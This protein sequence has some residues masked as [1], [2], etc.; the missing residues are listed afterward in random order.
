MAVLPQTPVP[1]G[2]NPLPD[3]NNKPPVS[4]TGG[5]PGQSGIAKQ[6][7]QN[8]NPLLQQHVTDRLSKG[9]GELS[10][11]TR[12]ELA[13]FEERSKQVRAEEELKL[14]RLGVL[15]NAGA[16]LRA[17]PELTGQLE[18]ARLDILA[19]GEER[20]AQAFQGG[21]ALSGQAAGELFTTAGL[22]GELFGQKTLAQQQQ[23]IDNDNAALQRAISQGQTTG[24]FTDPVTGVTQDTLQARLA[25]KQ[26]A[27]DQALALG[28]IDGQKTIAQQQ[29]DIDNDNAALQ[30]AISQGNVTGIF[31]DP[32]TGVASDILQK[33]LADKQRALDEAIAL[34]EVGGE[35]TLEGQS[36]EIDQLNAALQRAISQGQSTGVFVDPETGVM[37]DTLEKQ[38]AD[39]QQALAEAALTGVFEGSDTLSG[40]KMAIDT[41]NAALQRAISQGQL[42]GTF[43]DPV[44][45]A[46]Q[47]TLEKHIAD[48]QQ[49]LDEAALTGVFD[50]E[51]TLA[52]QQQNLADLNAAMDRAI[53]QGQLTGTFIDPDTNESSVSLQSKIADAQQKHQTAQLTELNRAAVIEENLRALNAAMDRAVAQ[54]QLTGV[55][56]DPDTGKGSQTL[57]A[58][59]TRAELALDQ[60]IRNGDMVIN[61][62]DV[63]VREAQQDVNALNAAMARAIQSGEATGEFTDP[64]SGD[65]QETL[66]AELNRKSAALAQSQHNLQE[67]LAVGRFGDKPTLDKLRLDE[68]VRAAKAGEVISADQVAEITRSNLAGERLQS[69][70]LT[71]S[72]T[73][74]DPVTQAWVNTTTLESLQ[75]DFDH[76]LE[77]GNL[78]G[79]VKYE[80]ATGTTITKDTMAA[81][82]M[83]FE[84]MQAAGLIDIDP[85]T[86]QP[87]TT[88]MQTL[89]AQA[90]QLEDDIQNGKLSLQQQA[91]AFDQNVTEAEITGLYNKF[92]G[93]AGQFFAA[94]DTSLGDMNFIAEFDF[95]ADGTINNLDWNEFQEASQGG[96]V[97]TEGAKALVS[98]LA[99]QSL[100]RD[101]ETAGVTGN[102]QYKDIDGNTVTVQT[103]EELDRLFQQDIEAAQLFG[104]RPPQTFSYDLLQEKTEGAFVKGTDPEYDAAFDI[105]QDG[106]TD[107]SDRIVYQ[108]MMDAA[109]RNRVRGLLRSG[110]LF[111]DL[112]FKDQVKAGQEG[113]VDEQGDIIPDAISIDEETRIDFLGGDAE[114]GA[115]VYRPEGSLTL[116][117]RQLGVTEA[118]VGEA[119]RQFNRTFGEEVA[120][121]KSQMSG[122]MV[123]ENGYAEFINVWNPETQQYDIRQPTTPER[124]QFELQMEQIETLMLSTEAPSFYRINESKGR[125]KGFERVI[126]RQEAI[127]EGYIN[128][129]GS[130]GWRVLEKVGDL[131][132]GS[133]ITVDGTS[134]M[135]D[136]ARNMGLEF[137]PDSPLGQEQQFALIQS[138]MGLM[139]QP[140]NPTFGPRGPTGA[141]QVAGIIDAFIPD[142]IGF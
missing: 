48:N 141:Q 28:T 87:S 115:Y 85:V 22:T 75:Q 43:V 38:I 114:T 96:G 37:Q 66:Q 6:I 63:A 98:E 104:E 136:F 120:Q 111:D 134:G 70:E 11:Q 59:L 14:Q 24:V 113:M 73:H 29:Q 25:D 86:G 81:K 26:H 19:R 89:E 105:N 8:I 35:L 83:A 82:L 49:A 103:R 110:V 40:Q 13:D 88:A 80:D 139:F 69:G 64:I 132:E 121:F 94:M 97:Q 93:R 79:A 32:V 138:L 102:F 99:N 5:L 12:R 20:R 127:D 117:A 71:G 2:D 133:T 125:I 15:R 65:S 107:L 137:D 10:A 36:L 55:F 3:A 95:N 140:V 126:T 109:N 118:Q 77:M 54:G 53:A 57:Q 84:K 90:L 116:A 128:E 27:L 7:R 17:L 33:Q 124:E 112:D 47:E 42:T 91:Q 18:R 34:G 142:S 23:D 67:G 46:T 72:F 122:F 106:I 135:E 101:L 119:A 129:D 9:P 68:A 60:S 50:G 130:M 74:W 78:T 123:D 62:R 131:G 51:D 92:G 61:Q 31:I 44:T 58:E 52:G 45:N 76:I 16:P 4:P 39:N 1:G 41:L 108:D 56:V 30:R 21:L 100:T